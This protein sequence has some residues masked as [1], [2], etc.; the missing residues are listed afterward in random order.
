MPKAS[1]HA[2]YWMPPEGPLA[3]FGAAWLGWDAAS[4]VPVTPPTFPGIPQ[5]EV[6]AA[7]QAPRKYGLHAT[8]KAPFR[9]VPDAGPDD[10]AG[11]VAR[12]AAAIPPLELDGLALAAVGGFLALVPEGRTDALGRLAFHV[13][14]Q[15]DGLRARPL[16]DELDRRRATGLSARQDAL[17]VRWGYPYVAD[18]FRF[19][20]TLTGSLG[21]D[22]RA[23][24]EAA[25]RPTLGPMLPRP[26]RIDE[27]AIACEG[28]DGRFRLQSRHRLSG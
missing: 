10:L 4:G 28:P 13:V 3:R 8:I 19:H 12:L 16:Q 15:L 7:T 6:A 21:P 17:L 26:F 23:A 11:A 24:L 22:R 9:L 1:R 2:V 20:V 5:D 18:E 25:L 27:L 14:E